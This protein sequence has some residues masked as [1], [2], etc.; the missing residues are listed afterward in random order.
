MIG[1]H[2]EKNEK[3]IEAIKMVKQPR[4]NLIRKDISSP[5]RS[6]MSQHLGSNLHKRRAESQENSSRYENI[7]R[8]TDQDTFM[9]FDQRKIPE[10]ESVLSGSKINKYLGDSFS[11]NHDSGY[12]NHPDR[13]MAFGQRSRESSLEK[14][15]KTNF[16]S[17]Q[18]K[19]NQ[20]SP[21]DKVVL[22]D[23]EDYTEPKND[24]VQMLS[25]QKPL[26]S[27]QS[28]L[29]FKGDDIFGDKSEQDS[30]QK[31]PAG[32]QTSL[33]RIKE[34]RAPSTEVIDLTNKKKLWE[35]PSQANPNMLINE[36]ISAATRTLKVAKE[37]IDVGDVGDGGLIGPVEGNTLDEESSEGEDFSSDIS[38]DDNEFFR[39]HIVQKHNELKEDKNKKKEK[40]EF[41]DDWDFQE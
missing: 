14:E 27:K 2:V 5:L 19:I 16:Q 22:E 39:G 7:Q 21:A 20:S 31:K 3:E 26:S 38:V 10:R 6:S 15:K 13:V 29:T 11:E 4:V 32:R 40:D 23:I 41:E 36:N 8:L 24:E 25:G 35:K 34:E 33:E 37:D 1:T 9:K 28:E 12:Q 17:L 18:R 30:H